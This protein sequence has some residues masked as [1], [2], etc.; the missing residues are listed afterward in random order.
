[1]FSFIIV[2]F[3]LLSAPRVIS[4]DP[5]G[6]P[7]PSTSAE[8]AADVDALMGELVEAVAAE[9]AE[10]SQS[11]ALNVDDEVISGL[12]ASQAPGGPCSTP[13][14]DDGTIWPPLDS[15]VLLSPVAAH[16][17]QQVASD[18]ASSSASVVF[19]A[20]AP[21]RRCTSVGGRRVA[22]DVEAG[23]AR[24][25]DDSFDRDAFE[26]PSTSAPPPPPV[27]RRQ[28]VYDVEAGFARYEDDSFNL[29]IEPAEAQDHPAAAAA[30]AAADAEA[31][32]AADAEADA[33]VDTADPA[34]H[35]ATT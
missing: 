35:D 9:N 23:F 1:M 30:A 25:L 29:D 27:A 10:P 32:A 34:A 15:A 19:V 14:R 28:V 2:F 22:F 8:V 4:I 18:S 21:P 5:A 16:P 7:L 26:L 24:F 20:E 12:R 17:S 11:E 3:C 31:D 6:V 33:V 13:A